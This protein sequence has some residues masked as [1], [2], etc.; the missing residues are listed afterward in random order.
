LQSHVPFV[1]EGSYPVRLGN[2]LRPLVDALPAFRRI[3]EAVEAARRSVWVAVTFLSS[4]FQMPDGRGSFFDL[5]DRAVERGLDVR[6]IFWRPDEESMGYGEVF[7]GSPADRA[8]L[9]SRDSRFRARWDR[10]DRGYCQHQKLWL[11][12]AGE[13]SETAFVGGINPTFAASSPGHA[14]S[15]Q[16]HDLYIEVTGPSSTDVHHNFVQRWNEASERL[17]ADGAWGETGDDALAYPLRASA[18]RGKSVVQVQRN[19][20]AGRYRE[21]EPAPGG[22]SI[23]SAA[24]ERTILMQYQRAID[25]ARS[26]IYI[27]NQAIPALALAGRL[28][29]AL[30]RGVEIV[31]LV[32][33]EPHDIVR[34]E[35]RDPAGQA[36]FERLAALAERKNFGLAGIAGLDSRGARSIVYV[37]AKAMLV[38]DAWATI[39]SC[40]LHAAS[41]LENTEM[42]VTFR[43][44]AVV[45]T[46]RCH[47]LAEHLGLDTS[48]LGDAAALRLYRRI[49][50]ENRAKRDGGRADWQ[51]LAFRIDATTYGV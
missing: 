7:S 11:I 12:D 1:A 2:L 50:D 5:L 27:E 18:P 14:G 9:R 25:A 8:M 17:A 39:G 42:N 30:D 49:A 19:L 38:D 31:A 13:P 44:P 45:R 32:P 15:G 26:S 22:N 41:L 21:R 3:C 34:S 35:R 37:H 20:Q 24:G 29:A 28:E 33:A 23:D 40:N 47:L 43:D 10:A 16:R 48:S 46:L 36:L 51:G 6:I 4:R